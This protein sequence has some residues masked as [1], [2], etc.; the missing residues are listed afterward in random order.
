M[1]QRDEP[2]PDLLE[3]AIRDVTARMKKARW[4]IPS[5]FLQFSHYVRAAFQMDLT[6]STGYPYTIYYPT[7]GSFLGMKD[8]EIIDKQRFLLAWQAVKKQIECKRSDPIRIFIKPEPHSASKLKEERYRIISAVSVVDHL[9]DHM[10]H[11]DMNDAMIANHLDL[12]TCVG[13]SPYNGGYKIFAYDAPIA[14]DRSSWD[15]T[16]RKWMQDAILRV[17]E[18]LCENINPDWM[19]LAKFRY[20]AMFGNCTYVTSAGAHYRQKFTGVQKSGQYNTITDNSLG[21]VL[22]DSLVN[23]KLGRSPSPSFKCMGDDTIQ[24]IDGDMGEYIEELG[25]WCKLKQPLYSREFCGLNFDGAIEPVYSGKH[26]FRLLHCKDKFAPEIA[27][28][29]RLFYH[30]S[31]MKEKLS[32]IFDDLAPS[33]MTPTQFSEIWEG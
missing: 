6:S 5:D 29:Y 26:A 16:V 24:E 21:Q 7:V 10:L 2:E 11:S 12:P 3:A 1:D 25:K 18:R 8:G 4:R 13:W 19:E 22:L 17:R 14:L 20:E 33:R 28:S 30:R 15:W 23:L 27:D 9:I 31:S 32:R